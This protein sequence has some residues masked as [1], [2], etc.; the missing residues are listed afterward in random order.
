[1]IIYRQEDCEVNNNVVM[2]T[3]NLIINGKMFQCNSGG[4]GNGP[5]PAGL[6]Q[7]DAAIRIP[8]IAKNAA[9]KRTEFPWY[10]RL[11]PLFKTSRDG[12]LIHPD[13]NVKGSLGC[14]AITEN[15]KELFELLSILK[16]KCTLKVI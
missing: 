8:D 9:Y 4:W 11:T 7:V 5:L 6:Y 13:G 3:G 14:V 12:L 16:G 10:A 1:M 2:T 15:D